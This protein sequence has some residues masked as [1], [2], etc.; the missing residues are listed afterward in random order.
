MNS[1]D[2]KRE[3]LRLYLLGLMSA[4]ERQAVEERI[5]TDQSDYDEVLIVEEELMD[6]YL[7][8]KLSETE[9]EAFNTHFIDPPERQGDLRFAQAF[10]TYIRDNHADVA[11]PATTSTNPAPKPNFFAGWFP[12]PRFGLAVA[13]VLLIGVL[14]W[15][16]YRSLNPRGPSQVIAVTLSGAPVIREGGSVQT[17]TLPDG[18]VSV[19][20]SLQVPPAPFENY[21][22]VL[23]NA[24]GNVLL[25]S[26][27]SKRPPANADQKIVVNV[28]A[29]F[30]PNGDYQF[31]L[32]GLNEKDEPDSVASYRFR[33]TR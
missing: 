23:H 9:R 33:V 28:P 27:K 15:I 26:E 29:G 4:E 8:N 22:A 11:E 32:N 6:D 18:D 12:V 24:D 7:A 13:V 30:L 19:Q 16:G 31:V 10:K 20:F 5:I 21:Q 1:E 14:S 25:T 17:V 3:D 2:T